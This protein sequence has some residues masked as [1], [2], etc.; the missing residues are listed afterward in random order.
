[1]HEFKVG[2]SLGI[3][4]SFF[5]LPPNDIYQVPWLTKNARSHISTSYFIKVHLDN[6]KINVN[7]EP[8]LAK[9]FQGQKNIF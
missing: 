1:M 5:Q 7:E 4:K 2:C 9:W 8:F 6:R 3:P